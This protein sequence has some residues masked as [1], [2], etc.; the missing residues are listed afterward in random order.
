MADNGMHPDCA[1]IVAANLERNT[2]MTDRT[3]I[4]PTEDE[5]C[6][7]V[8]R[9]REARIAHLDDQSGGDQ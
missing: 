2:H 8:H 9:A 1:R 5:L 7:A 4:Y 6:T 3:S